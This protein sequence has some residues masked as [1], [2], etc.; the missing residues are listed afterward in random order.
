MRQRLTAAA[1][2]LTLGALVA[3]VPWL[4]IVVVTTV[5]VRFDPTTPDGWWQALTTRDDGTLLVWLL[6]ILGA[7][8]W[9]ILMLA[10]VV[11][12]VSRARR[13][14][15]PRLPGLG[16]PQAL[17]HSLVAAVVGAAVSTGAAVGGIDA[18]A[19][20]GPAPVQTTKPS[21]LPAP[22]VTTPKA[23]HAIQ[24][25][26]AAETYVVKKGDTLWDIA[27]DKLGDPYAYPKI[28]Q[29]SKKTVQPDG[30]HLANPD[31]IPG[32]EAHHPRSPPSRRPAERAARTGQG[33]PLAS[34]RPRDSSGDAERPDDTT[35]VGSSHSGR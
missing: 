5:R 13:L 9:A 3:G 10:L 33:R 2:L 17:A 16:L 34:R 1:A 32:L 20:P 29:A 21:Q 22:P 30:R 24:E 23:H 8:A 12:I 31:L 27:D 35:A 6:T 11:E 18:L 26:R 7:V 19:A 14:S 28:F 4:L 25:P 15:V